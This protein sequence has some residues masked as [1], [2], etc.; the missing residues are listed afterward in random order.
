MPPLFV[1]AQCSRVSAYVTE[2]LEAGAAPSANRTELRHLLSSGRDG[3][4]AAAPVLRSCDQWNSAGRAACVISRKA[5]AM[6]V[7]DQQ[8]VDM[9][10]INSIIPQ[11]FTAVVY[12][13]SLT[14]L[15]VA[16]PATA[17]LLSR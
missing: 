4:A 1:V 3:H 5:A 12:V 13:R 7:S 6:L 14:A 10:S 2:C 15:P 8:S 9:C 17:Q 16:A 11:R